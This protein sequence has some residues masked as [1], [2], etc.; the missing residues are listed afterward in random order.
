MYILSYNVH[1]IVQ[2]TYYCTMYILLYN[3]HII[4][5][6]TYYRKMYIL[7]YMYIMY[8]INLK[9]EILPVY[10]VTLSMSFRTKISLREQSL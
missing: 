3:V 4:V 1:I 5:Q 10:K 9:P 7:L 2:C 8:K 6:C